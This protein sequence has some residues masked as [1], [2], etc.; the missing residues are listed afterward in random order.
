MKKLAVLGA[1]LLFATGCKPTEA[2]NPK[3][4]TVLSKADMA[5]VFV[6]KPAD[7]R[8]KKY[9]GEPSTNPDYPKA[10][11]CQLP[12][13]GWYMCYHPKDTQDP[14]AGVCQQVTK[15][16][17]D[18]LEVNDTVTCTTFPSYESYRKEH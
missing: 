2:S 15:D 10:D 13:P 1:V 14:K 12:G 17:Y 3:L 7:P 11:F 18:N 5:S 8:C 4:D 16:C 9:G 6:P